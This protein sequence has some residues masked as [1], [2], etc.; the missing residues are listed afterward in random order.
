MKLVEL[1]CRAHPFLLDGLRRLKEYQ[2]DMMKLNPSSKKNAFF[3]T[4]EE[5]LNRPE[6]LKHQKQLENIQPTS[7]SLVIL[8][9][10]RNIL[11]KNT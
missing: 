11:T 4:G 3:Y 5:T 8:P 6:V 9:H 2:K 1:R 7:N 10:T